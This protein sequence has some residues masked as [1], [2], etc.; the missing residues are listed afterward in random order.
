[1]T[2]TD[3]LTFPAVARDGLEFR[4]STVRLFRAI[5]LQQ[6]KDTC[7]PDNRVPTHQRKL[8]FA[9][10][11]VYDTHRLR[12]RRATATQPKLRIYDCVVHSKVVSPRRN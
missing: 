2:V 3:P 12:V 5:E 8:Y 9:A 4:R 7:S 1:M 11:E 10:N 6:D